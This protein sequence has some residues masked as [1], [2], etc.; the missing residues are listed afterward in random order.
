[1]CRSRSS[2]ADPGPAGP[3]WWP[4]PVR[5]AGGAHRVPP[6]GGLGMNT[7]IGDVMNLCWKVAGVHQ[8]WAG[9]RLLDSYEIERRQMGLRN[10]QLGVRCTRVM[11]GWTLF[12]GFEEDNAAAD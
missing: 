10:V 4:S 6:L 5:R 2:R 11:D 1:M 9:P 7:G 3:R 8:G 12:P